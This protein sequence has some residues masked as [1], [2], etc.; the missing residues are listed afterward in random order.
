MD[1]TLCSRQGEEAH[2]HHLTACAAACLPAQLARTSVTGKLLP[3]SVVEQGGG[4]WVQGGYLSRGPP[5]A[6]KGPSLG[7]VGSLGGLAEQ[8]P[9]HTNCYSTIFLQLSK[10]APLPHCP[11]GMG[12]RRPPRVQTVGLET[13]GRVPGGAWAGQCRTTRA[14]LLLCLGE[15]C[16]QPKKE[17]RGERPGAV[18]SQHFSHLK[19]APL[20]CTFS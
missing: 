10:L 3:P 11:A 15:L 2:V 8:V 14:E 12:S 9:V 16:N 1:S 18:D 5:G 13:R 4:R 17:P 6:G 7:L 19:T 20:G